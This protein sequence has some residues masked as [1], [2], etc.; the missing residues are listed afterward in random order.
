MT[1]SRQFRTRLLGGILLAAL[2]AGFAWA[3]ADAN[4]FKTDQ[5][6]ISYIIGTQ[7]VGSL[8]QQGVELNVES[9]LRG[10]RAAWAGQKS[11][12]TPEEQT[13]IM[14]AFQQKMIAKLQAQQQQQEAQALAKLGKENEWKLKL[15][16]PELMKFDPQKEYFWILE[17]NKGN[18]Q[19]K[20]MPDVAPMHVTSTIFLTNKGF[21]DGTLFHRVIPGFMVQGGDPLGTGSGGPGYQY[22]G[23]FSPKVTYDRPFL[24]G[25][26]NRS[27]PN[28][29]GSQFFITVV[30]V[31]QLNNKHTIFGE[32]VEGQDTVKKLEAG[33]T[34]EGKTKEE[35]K[36]VKARITEQ[37]K[38]VVSAKPVTPAQQSPP[39]ASK[40][41]CV[42]VYD[43]DPFGPGLGTWYGAL[44]YTMGESVKPKLAMPDPKTQ[45]VVV[46]IVSDPRPSFPVALE[47]GK[48]YLWNG[49]TDFSFLQ[50]IDM[51]LSR[52]E[53]VALVG[54]QTPAQAAFGRPPF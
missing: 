23:E 29:D 26:A 15:T 2:P 41:D 49:G 47:P 32:V 6:K 36:I 27:Q 35:L 5:D 52:Q 13:K 17:T 38:A 25:M 11:P 37:A 30:A 9:F 19:I 20:L 24:L 40:V 22:D 39:K 46:I 33:G 50:T 7:V 21:Y 53:M 45:R 44:T 8:R 14:T 31:P 51:K 10:F 54:L 1:V 42:F 43:E 34:R 28:T 48:A 18:I 16:K 4:D 3:A 12:F